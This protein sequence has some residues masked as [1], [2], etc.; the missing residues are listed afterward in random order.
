MGLVSTP[1]AVLELNLKFNELSL[2]ETFVGRLLYSKALLITVLSP[3][4]RDALLN[5]F[6]CRDSRVCVLNQWAQPGAFHETKT[7]RVEAVL[8]AVG[9]VYAIAPGR[10]SRNHDELLGALALVPEARVIIV[11]RPNATIPEAVRPRVWVIPELDFG[12]YIYL[13]RRARFC[14]IPLLPVQHTCGIRVWFQSNAMGIPVT[15]TLTDSTA[16]YAGAGAVALFYRSGEVEALAGHLAKLWNDDAARDSLSAQSKAALL[17]G[18]SVE[19]YH[20]KTLNM[21]R[22]LLRCVESGKM[23]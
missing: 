23:C 11:G 4:D 16:H 7:G 9:P 20:S 1:I 2:L 19:A 22:E 18:F 8:N 21:V 3:C 17:S 12:E 13:T 15:I 6:R 10:S 14:I 5:L